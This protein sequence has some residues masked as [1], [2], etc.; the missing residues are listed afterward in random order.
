T[1]R[2]EDVIHL[3]GPAALQGEAP[4]YTTMESAPIVRWLVAEA[5]EQ[6]GHPDSAAAHFE[7]AIAPPPQGGKNITHIRTA[8]S[9]GHRRLVLLYAS[10][11]RREEARRHWE[12]FSATFTRPDA[13]MQPLVDEARMALASA[14]DLARS[15]KR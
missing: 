8:D 9:F 5:Y 10:M 13:E 4:R 14:E 3:L 6:L 7:R 1:D 15:A 11:G 12:F 2:W